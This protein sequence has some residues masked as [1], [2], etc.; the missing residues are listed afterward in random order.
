MIMRRYC[1]SL[2]WAMFAMGV[3]V[4]PVGHAQGLL[5]KAF[6]P[7]ESAILDSG[8]APPVSPRVQDGHGPVS[9][10]RVLV[11]LVARRGSRACPRLVAL[12]TGMAAQGRHVTPLH[13]YALGIGGCR[14]AEP[15]LWRMLRFDSSPSRRAMALEA[16]GMIRGRSFL[17]VLFDAVRRP[18][19]RRAVFLVLTMFGDEVVPAVEAAIRRGIQPDVLG[20]SLAWIGTKKSLAAL[21]RLDRDGLV[22]ASVWVEA[23]V[24][25]ASSRIGTLLFDAPASIRKAAFE[26]VRL[27]PDPRFS[28]GLMAMLGK[29]VGATDAI[30]E[31]LGLMRVR[32]AA[33]VISRFVRDPSVHIR[34]GAVAALGAIGTDEAVRVLSRYV[35]P[36]YP[37]DFFRT[38]RA[39]AT[40]RNPHAVSVLVGQI[41]WSG[42]MGATA[43][44]A[45]GL[46][47]RDR[48]R[49]L[50]GSR[51]ARRKALAKGRKVLAAIALRSNDARAAAAAH[52]LALIGDRAALSRNLAILKKQYRPTAD[53][54]DK[55][56]Q[57]RFDFGSGFNG[58]RHGKD[59][60]VGRGA[61][62][63][64]TSRGTKSK[65]TVEELR[66]RRF[67]QKQLDA[68]LAVD[69][70]A[71]RKD[72]AETLV[73]LLRKDI[74]PR[75]SACA[76]WALRGS[77]RW[78]RSVLLHAALYSD[79]VM[80]SWNAAAAL[81]RSHA[82]IS[83]L[84]RLT[85]ALDSVVVANGFVGLGPRLAHLAY[86]LHGW[87]SAW[88]V[89][90][91]SFGH[92][93]AR[94]AFMALKIR[95]MD[96]VW[97]V[98]WSL[99][100]VV[101]RILGRRSVWWLYG[102]FPMD[103]FHDPAPR[104][105][106]PTQWSW[107]HSL[108]LGRIRLDPWND[109]LSLRLLR[110][111]GKSDPGRSVRVVTPSGLI[112][113]TFSDRFGF[114]ALTRLESGLCDVEVAPRVKD[115]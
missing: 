20:R 47:L 115:R 69:G 88:S 10:T 14:R 109:F 93:W 28:V 41:R 48:G 38:L 11:R 15:L 100:R 36:E 79:S 87:R 107:L 21:A 58:G 50:T 98:Q 59:K 19:Y 17:P 4:S 71:S 29:G 110:S 37:V 97:P 67:I 80:V 94:Q 27:A 114:V 112:V 12:V 44:E 32:D 84:L 23:P 65:P 6:G 51:A 82:S 78:T 52:A 77:G 40:S 60:I 61:D 53:T 39:L 72:V 83:V 22:S 42:Q 7:D 62:Q 102:I 49:R 18:I 16:L 5:T 95:A 104:R 1:R 30:L 92:R 66:H 99:L 9:W 24:T 55:V 2:G 76:A 105:V 13:L 89:T 34:N 54:S 101:V 57:A 56:G 8:W 96:A 106:N 111:E 73:A 64:R 68:C 81:A 31:L 85:R 90:D 75:L 86:G 45:L 25:A 113:W 43:I 46:L 33:A 74:D 91:P 103:P 108:A 26:A 3:L 70:F 35:R 63:A